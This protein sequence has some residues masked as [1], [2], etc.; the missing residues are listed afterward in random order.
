MSLSD[1]EVV[2]RCLAGEEE[3]FHVLVQKYE[4]P[5][6][7]LIHRMVASDEDTVDLTQETF[8]K[9]FRALEQF[10]PDRSFSSWLY[11]I[12]S[13]QTIDF[14]RKRRLRT[15]SIDGDPEVDDRPALDLVD[16]GPRPDALLDAGRRREHLAQLVGR[17]APHYRIVVEL[18]YQQQRSY[19]EITEI[20]DLP[21]GT[22]K[23]RLHRA[24]HQLRE[25]MTGPDPSPEVEGAPE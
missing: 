12:A 5:V 14:L 13:N 19:E 10:D 20:L 16:A 24:H 22:V 17:L 2:R 7:Y 21:L 23:A 9:V 8:I 15:I 4:R 18:R 11:K 6:Y 1:T 25:W 3:A